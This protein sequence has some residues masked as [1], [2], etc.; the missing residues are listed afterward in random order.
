MLRTGEFVIGSNMYMCLF[1]YS[2]N[3]RIKGRY[4]RCKI[5]LRH[6]MAEASVCSKAAI[7]VWGICLGPCFVVCF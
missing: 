1:T 2:N 5:H 4:M 7:L 6:S 3:R